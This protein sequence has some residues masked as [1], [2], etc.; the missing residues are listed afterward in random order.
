MV[1]AEIIPLCRMPLAAHAVG[2]WRRS[3]PARA[4][5]VHAAAPHPDGMNIT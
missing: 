4:S 2:A 1:F 3:L 5:T